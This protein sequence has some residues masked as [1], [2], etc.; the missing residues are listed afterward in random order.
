MTFGAAGPWQ[1]SYGLMNKRGMELAVEEINKSTLL[2]DRR[3]KVIDRDD[4]ADGQRATAI[5]NEFVANP[6]IVA[7]VG[8]VNSGTMVAAARIYDGNLPAVATT[9]SSPDITG[10]SPWVFRVISSDST[11]GLDMARFANRLGRKRAAIVYENDN[12]GRG[13]AESFRRSFQGEIVSYDAVASDTR[14]FEPF[15]ALYRQRNV[16]LVTMAGTDQSG[17]AMMREARRQ[18]FTA[19]FLGGDGWTG[20]L[21][22]TAVAEGAYV[23]APFTAEDPRPEAQRFVRAFRAKYG[24]DPDGNAALAFDATNLLARAVASGGDNRKAIRDYLASLT[25]ENAY[26]GVTGSIRFRPDGDP[27]GKSFVITRVQGNKLVVE[28]R[29]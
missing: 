5:A 15:V 19:A 12:Y 4:G 14:D 8:H 21:Q 18:G 11:N 28:G 17:L 2:G 16:D 9:A 27:V 22:D 24:V 23:A 13:L 3:L 20:I 1:E 10:I 29:Q 7:V 25:A 6:E 26:R